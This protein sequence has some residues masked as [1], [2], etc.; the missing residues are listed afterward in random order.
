MICYPNAKINLGLNITSK[1]PDGFH[2]ISSVFLPIQWQDAL[3]IVP[4]KTTTFQSAGIPIPG[5]ADS[6]LCLKAYQLLAKDHQLPPVQIILQKIIPI[7]AGLG[8]GSADASFT[9]TELNRQFNLGLTIAEMEQYA[10]Q[11][12][13]DC[14]FFIQNK[15]VLAEGT[16]T[17]FQPIDCDLADHPILLVNPNIHIGTAEAYSGITPKPSEIAIKKVVEEYPMTE[18]K[19]HLK[20]DFED[21]IFPKYPEIA[22]IKEQLYALGAVYASMSG[23]GATVYGIFPMGVEI[24]QFK[25]RFSDSYLIH[26]ALL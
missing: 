24:D 7:G 12:G 11:L 4:A 6:N 21:S 2:N 18:W 13:S 8:G 20:N 14:P 1:R 17:D 16:G 9:I 15:P 26:S 3:E 19:H 22:K 23:S 10:G 5:S 25:D